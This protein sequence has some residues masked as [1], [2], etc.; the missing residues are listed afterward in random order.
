MAVRHFTFTYRKYVSIIFFK[1]Q[2][3]PVLI[4][5]SWRHE[6]IKL[7]FCKSFEKSWCSHKCSKCNLCCRGV[8]KGLLLFEHGGHIT[9]TPDWVYL[10]FQTM[11]IKRKVTAKIKV[12]LTHSKFWDNKRKVSVRSKKAI[13]QTSMM[14]WTDKHQSAFN[15]VSYHISPDKTL[16]SACSNHSRGH[17]LSSWP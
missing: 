10:H 5:Y 6:K 14:S 11:E 13:A 2:T 8:V 9:F 7:Y 1:K 12:A 17:R 4:P 3:V 16:S 15:C